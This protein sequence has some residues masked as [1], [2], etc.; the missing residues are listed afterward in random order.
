MGSACYK[1]HSTEKETNSEYLMNN[2]SGGGI[3]CTG[4]CRC[5]DVDATER[6]LTRTGS[7]GFEASRKNLKK[8]PPIDTAS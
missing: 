8:P 1:T 7:R 6:S 5:T 4:D 2:Q 3:M